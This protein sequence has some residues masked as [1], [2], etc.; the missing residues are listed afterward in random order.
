MMWNENILQ[1]IKWNEEITN[2]EQKEAT[3][4]QI[5]LKVKDGDVIGFGSGSTS[6]LAIHTI[7]KKIKAEN[8]NVLAI[9]TSYEVELLCQNLGIPTTTLNKH[10]P[11]WGFDGADEVYV[12]K[13]PNGEN[14]YWLIKG[15]GGAL[16]R[17]KLIMAASEITYILV[18]DT[19]LVNNLGEKFP[20][21]VEVIPE[22]LHFVKES[23]LKMNIGI[24]SMDLRLAKGKDGPIITEYG[25]F[26][27]DVKFSEIKQGTEHVIKNIPGVLESGLF[28][29][30]N[31]EVLK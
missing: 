10:K 2:R 28:I 11:N 16:F 25:N 22:A 15:R 3:V 31:I 30:Y 12:D 8:L 20:I 5:A 1:K 24:I 4:K 14:R 21:P 18:D 27:L 19:K 17:E 9:P 6:F 26:I 7:A 23:L 29:G 13:Y